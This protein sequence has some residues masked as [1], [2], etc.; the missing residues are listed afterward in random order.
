MDRCSDRRELAE[1]DPLTFFIIT[2]LMTAERE[3]AEASVPPRKPTPIG[4]DSLA[5]VA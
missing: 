1:L 5:Q 2:E 4:E 3:K